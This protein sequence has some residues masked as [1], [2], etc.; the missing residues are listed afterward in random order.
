MDTSEKERLVNEYHQRNVRWTD[1][2]LVQLSYFNN[3]VLTL[4]I[5]FISFSYRSLLNK[6][7][8]I[9]FENIDWSYTLMSFSLVFMF[10]ASYKGLI[11]SLNRLMD[12]RITRQIV[13]IRQRMLEYSDAKM[14]ESTPTQMKWNERLNLIFKLFKNNYP[15][16]TIEQ[17]KSYRNIEQTK[18]ESIKR[19]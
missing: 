6:D 5:G 2:T 1:K 9:S 18:K 14:D 4:S 15:K 13:Q 10:F 12:F 17:C 3:L 8:K 11:V 16:I 7:L 19:L